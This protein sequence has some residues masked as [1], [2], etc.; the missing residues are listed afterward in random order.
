VSA[1]RYGE[2]VNYELAKML[3]QESP[4]SAVLDVGCGA[5]QDGAIAAANGAFVIGLENYHPSAV[6]A[7]KRLAKV[8]EVDIE[9]DV[10]FANVHLLGYDTLVFGDVL[11]HVREPLEVLRRFLPWLKPGGRVLISLPN[12]AAW[13][14]RLALLFGNFEYA[15]KGILDSTHLRFFTRAS[16]IRL[17]REAGLRVVRVRSNPLVLRPVLEALRR[18]LDG[19]DSSWHRRLDKWLYKNYL[20]FVRPV[21]G[22]LVELSWPELLSFQTV[23]EAELP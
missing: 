12:V 7:R 16:A 1:P 17:V 14:V 3:S 15:S 4:L 22:A 8:L 6:I 18:I 5:G 19:A 2:E 13:P 20:R 21:E 23:I 10:S 9:Q 11:E